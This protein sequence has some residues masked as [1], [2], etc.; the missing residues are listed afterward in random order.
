MLDTPLNSADDLQAFKPL[1]DLQ[2]LSMVGTRLRGLIQ[3]MD[4]RLKARDE[5][6]KLKD[7]LRSIREDAP[8][9]MQSIA[10]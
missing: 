3:V 1:G 9:T 10:I 7:S 5:F 6:H 2:I 4:E 8:G